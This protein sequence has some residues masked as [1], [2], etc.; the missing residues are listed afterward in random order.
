[1][2]EETRRYR[3]S[4]NYLEYLPTPRTTFVTPILQAE[5]ERLAARQPMDTLSMKRHVVR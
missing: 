5:L 1:M 2:E 3:P 4:K